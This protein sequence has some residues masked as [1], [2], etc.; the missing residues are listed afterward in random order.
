MGG[1]YSEGGKVL[2]NSLIRNLSDNVISVIDEDAFED[3]DGLEDLRLDANNIRRLTLSSVPT[4]L[5]RLELQGNLMDLMPD[6]P[7]EFEASRLVYLYVLMLSYLHITVS[8]FS[9]LEGLTMSLFA[10]VEI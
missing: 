9:G 2:T 3:V 8:I 10:C 1:F 5:E 7:D 4:N 6:F